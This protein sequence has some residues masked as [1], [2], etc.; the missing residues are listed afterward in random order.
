MRLHHEV[1]VYVKWSSM[2]IGYALWPILFHF[3]D[4]FFQAIIFSTFLKTRTVACFSPLNAGFVIPECHPFRLVFLYM[5]S[6]RLVSLHS[7]Q[8]MATTFLM[9]IFLFSF[10]H[11]CMG[12][13]LRFYCTRLFLRHVYQT[14]ALFYKTFVMFEVF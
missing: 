4:M 6:W 2:C 13:A 14:C 3:Y 1:V 10:E 7:S 9:V 8:D 11:W 5:K 12:Y